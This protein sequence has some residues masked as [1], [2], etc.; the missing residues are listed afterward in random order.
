MLGIHRVLHY[1]IY[2]LTLLGV[3]HGYDESA[4]DSDHYS[5]VSYQLGHPLPGTEQVI[6]GGRGEG[7][8]ERGRGGE[9]RVLGAC[10]PSEYLAAMRLLL[11]PFLGRNDASWRPDDRVLHA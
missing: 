9:G 3:S 2:C 7:G 6:E 10:P 4:E 8:R 1:I 11:R 5:S